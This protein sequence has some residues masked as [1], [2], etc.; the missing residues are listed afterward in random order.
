MSSYMQPTL[1]NHICR[2][3]WICRL[4]P[5]HTW[6]TIFRPMG[7]TPMMK[8][9]IILQSAGSCALRNA[10]SG[11]LIQRQIVNERRRLRVIPGYFFQMHGRFYDFVTSSNCGL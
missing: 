1:P 3:T 8:V 10:T 2:N 9:V 4:L 5:L 6:Q 11:L 7:D